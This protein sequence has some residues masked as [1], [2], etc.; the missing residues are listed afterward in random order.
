MV[1]GDDMEALYKQVP[2]EILPKEYGGD[3]MTLD[4]LTGKWND[5]PCYS[6]ANAY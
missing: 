3:G 6:V 4:E 1:H 2:K 5:C